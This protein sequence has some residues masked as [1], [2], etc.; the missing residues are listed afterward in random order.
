VNPRGTPQRIRGGH[1]ANERAHVRWQRW[2][3][4]AVSAFPGPEEAKPAAMPRDH[5]LRLDD[6]NRRAPA[7]PG[8]REPRP[9]D[10]IG[11]REAKTRAPRS[12]DDGQLV[13]ERDDFWCSEA[14]DWTRNRNEWSSE[15]TT[16][17]TT[18]GYRRMPGTSIG[19]A[20]PHECEPGGDASVARAGEPS[21]FD[22][23]G[24][25]ACCADG[26]MQA[27]NL[28]GAYRVRVDEPL[29]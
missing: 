19:A 13:S 22:A 15:T 12:M 9:Q 18:A 7:A 6:V 10:S 26:W 1:V 25:T 4:G 23:A 29:R 21:L 8:V 2:A 17:D 11:R 27:D 3:A 16:D 14:R 28:S 20:H 5:R 24:L